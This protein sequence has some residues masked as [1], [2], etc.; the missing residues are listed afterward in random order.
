MSESANEPEP[1]DEAGVRRRMIVAIV[2]V[3]A[4][5]IFAVLRVMPVLLRPPTDQTTAT[6]PMPPVLK[7]APTSRSAPPTNRLTFREPVDNPQADGWD[8]EVFNQHAGK[9]LKIILKLLDDPANIDAEHLTPLVTE[10]FKCDA[11]HP[12][13][14]EPVYAQGS[15][16]MKRGEVNHTQH[17]AGVDGLAEALRALAAPFDRGTDRHGK[18]KLFRVEQQDEQV[19]TEQFFSYVATIGNASVEVNA[20]WTSHWRQADRDAPP[21]LV[22]LRLDAYEQTRHAGAAAKMFADVTESVLASN[23]SFPTAVMTPINTWTQ[24]MDMPLHVNTHALA[25]VAVGDVNG[26]GLDDLYVC[27]TGGLPN[28]LYVQ[29]PDGSVT[30]RSRESGADWI[31]RCEDALLLDLDNDGDQDLVVTI[32]PQVLVMANDGAGRFEVKAEMDTGQEMCTL[33]AADYDNDADLDL[34]VAIRLP[35]NTPGQVLV[36]RPYYDANNGARNFLYRNDGGWRFTDVTAEV[37]LDVNNA[38]FSL[39]SSWE[40]F[41]N[42]GDQD[43][44]V[45]NDFG[46]N[47]LYRN[48]G[49]RFTD[50]TEKADVEDIGTGMGVTW[51]D[52]NRDGYMDLYVSNMFSSAGRRI[53]AQRQFKTDLNPKARAYYQRLARGNTLYENLGN[54]TFKETTDIA[55]VTMGRWAWSSMFADINNDGLDDLVVGN[56][57]M[58]NENAADL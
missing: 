43:L 29:N 21:R 51:G 45:A 13:K 57:F 4:A 32:A 47:C 17:L 20:T 10:D 44:Y 16:T 49:G 25:G 48:D 26:D 23:P 31:E 58:T 22:D 30:D 6:I 38:R 52:Y 12:A 54:G 35:P 18:F 34:Y 9:Q 27:D 50:V 15:V 33:S 41:D 2:F 36:P 5:V 39:A 8:T 46:R 56:G 19:E 53:T 11:L 42:D 40:D 7:G 14:L 1:M 28:R 24:R 37:G 55:G 3:S